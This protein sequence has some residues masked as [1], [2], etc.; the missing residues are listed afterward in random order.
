[1]HW[2]Q[3]IDH[4]FLKVTLKEDLNDYDCKHSFERQVDLDEESLHIKAYCYEGQDNITKF[5][6]DHI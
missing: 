4:I 3:S 2:A 5:N 1:M 6:T